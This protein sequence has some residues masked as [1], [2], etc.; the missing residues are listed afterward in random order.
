MERGFKVTRSN[1]PAENKSSTAWWRVKVKHRV[2]VFNFA[3]SPRFAHFSSQYLWSIALGERAE[4]NHAE[5]S[6]RHSLDRC[7]LSVSHFEA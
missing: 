4:C 5:D 7:A 2:G 1:K 3:A 6:A